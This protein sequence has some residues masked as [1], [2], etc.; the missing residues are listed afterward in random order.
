MSIHSYVHRDANETHLCRVTNAI[1]PNPQTTT[2]IRALEGASVCF[3]Q[4]SAQQERG[5]SSRKSNDS[6]SEVCREEGPRE[7]EDSLISD[8][9]GVKR[10]IRGGLNAM[11]WSLVRDK[12]S[13]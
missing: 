11:S 10:C 12:T 4:R 8:A 13:D 9:R 7:W 1:Y 3:I 6:E 5:S 2:R